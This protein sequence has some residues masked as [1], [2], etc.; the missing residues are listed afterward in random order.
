MW[1]AST[2][3]EM[4]LRVQDPGGVNPAECWHPSP[5]GFRQASAAPM[6]PRNGWSNGTLS[7]AGTSS[8]ALLKTSRNASADSG[9]G[10][11]RRPRQ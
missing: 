10:A 4:C 1:S 6:P 5:V 9:P 7:S 8:P 2:G 11:R 3:S